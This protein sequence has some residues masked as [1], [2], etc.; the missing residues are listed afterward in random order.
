[1]IPQWLIDMTGA[2]QF[3]NNP[4]NGFQPTMGDALQGIGHSM[5]E[6]YRQQLGNRVQGAQGMPGPPGSPGALSLMPPSPP[7]P[8]QLPPGAT[9]PIVPQQVNLPAPLKFDPIQPPAVPMSA[10]A[11]MFRGQ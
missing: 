4:A 7:A 3:A 5:M 2:M 6:H 11:Q 8:M 1:M 10:I 9:P